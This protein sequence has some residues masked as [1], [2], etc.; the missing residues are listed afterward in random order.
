[1]NR[2]LENRW[3]ICLLLFCFYATLQACTPPKKNASEEKVGMHIDTVL[4]FVVEYPMSW[5]K[6]RRLTY[7]STDGEV[8][9]T[10]PEHPATLLLIRSYAKSSMNTKLAEQVE[11]ALQGYT[12]WRASKEEKLTIPAGDAWHITGQTT[13]NDVNIYLI[14]HTG[15]NYLIALTTPQGSIDEYQDLMGRV[16]PSFQVMSQ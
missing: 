11:Q 3:L 7:G 2:S 13:H 16:L 1:M 4:D 10:H 9:W 6:E 15:R 8:R 14:L 5:H 12:G